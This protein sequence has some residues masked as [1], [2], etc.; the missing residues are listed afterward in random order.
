[1]P[2]FFCRT[3]KSGRSN[4]PILIV[5]TSPAWSL[6]LT[7]TARRRRPLRCTT[8]TTWPESSWC[9]SQTKYGFHSLQILSSGSKIWGSWLWPFELCY[10]D[11]FQV[12]QLRRSVLFHLLT[13]LQN[14]EI[15]SDK[16]WV[17]FIYQCWCNG[18][19]HRWQSKKRSSRANC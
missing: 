8:P 3:S 18:K 4:L 9:S 7:S 6:T 13:V 1:M 19:K 2:P 5:S 11:Q 14:F 12:G 17:K 10:Q 16:F 15:F